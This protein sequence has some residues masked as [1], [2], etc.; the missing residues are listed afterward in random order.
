M[1]LPLIFFRAYNGLHGE[2]FLA[3]PL[4]RKANPR[5][6]WPQNSQRIV[7]MAG[8][9]EEVSPLRLRAPSYNPRRGTF[10][11]RDG[12]ERPCP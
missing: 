4:R 11:G 10:I 9:R 1:A 2:L 5:Q 8:E 12:Y 6:S 7:Q 3:P